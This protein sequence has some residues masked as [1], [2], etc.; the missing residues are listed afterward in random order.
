MQLMH[1]LFLRL[2]ACRCVRDHAAAEAKY[3]RVYLPRR[4][5]RRQGLGGPQ[6]ELQGG[7]VEAAGGASV[8]PGDAAGVGSEEKG[9][10]VGHAGG[11]GQDAS[12]TGVAGAT[13]K[14]ACDEESR[15]LELEDEGEET[16][17]I[18]DSADDEQTWCMLWMLY[19]KN[20]CRMAHDQRYLLV[21]HSAQDLLEEALL[22]WE[23]QVPFAHAWRD[24]YNQI[25]F[26]IV[27]AKFKA[28]STGGGTLSDAEALCLSSL[29]LLCKSFRNNLRA[30]IHLPELHMMWL[31]LLGL[32]EALKHR[33][34]ARHRDPV[35]NEIVQVLKEMLHAINEDPAF[36]KA[37]RESGQD[38][39][40][41]TST[42]IDA[43]CPDLKKELMTASSP[44]AQASKPVGGGGGVSGILGSL[45]GSSAA[46]SAPASAPA[47][48]ATDGA[49]TEEKG[50]A[51]FD[52]ARVEQHGP[53][54]ADASAA[55]PSND[56]GSGVHDQADSATS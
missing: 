31:K 3:P 19:V 33:I 6:G 1:C 11:V 17:G 49:A 30:I 12:A 24:C 50:E 26:P 38:M 22:C 27:S 42:V 21:A 35:S 25:I 5:L 9:A 14:S 45:F 34:I 41:L 47:D 15:G 44:H 37:Q 13:G 29:L 46:P 4:H 32:M 55:P 23:V 36:K 53:W 7:A 40:A 28:A 18:G 56:A 16:F 2:R 8:G 54:S 52:C 48:V 51:G 10:G 39:W 43:F 20:I